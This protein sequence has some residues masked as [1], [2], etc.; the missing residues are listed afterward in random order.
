LPFKRNLQRYSEMAGRRVEVAPPGG[1]K[2]FDFS[3][4][5]IFGGAGAR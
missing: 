3:F 2:S 1:P 5:R 4:D